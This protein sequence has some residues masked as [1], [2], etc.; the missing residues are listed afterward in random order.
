MRVPGPDSKTIILHILVAK[1][2]HCLY[3]VTD[4]LDERKTQSV[5]MVNTVNLFHAL[6]L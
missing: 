1:V 2:V 5:M 3:W 6:F 4:K